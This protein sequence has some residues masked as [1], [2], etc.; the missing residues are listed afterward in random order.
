MPTNEFT[1][2]QSIH[3]FKS[4]V[5]YLRK[6]L[7][8]PID[9]ETPADELTFDYKASELGI[10]DRL[11]VKVKEIKQLRPLTGNQPWGVFWIQF[12][13]KQLP[14]VVMRRILSALVKKQRGRSG[15]QKMWDLPDLMFISATG[16]GN[17]RGISFAHFQEVDGKPQLRTFAWDVKET[18]L[19][20]IKNVNL[21][22]LRWPTDNGRDANAWQEQWSEAFSVPHRYVPTTAEMLAKKMAQIASY[23]REAVKLIYGMEHVGRGS[24]HKLHMNLKL[25]LISDLSEDD[26]ADM[27]AQ[28]VTYGLFA[29]RATRSGGFSGSDAT[30]LIEH[31]NPFLRELLEQM[32]NQQSLD[33]DELGVT[34]LTDLL[35]KVNMEAILQSFGKQKRGEDPVIHFYETFMREYDPAQKTKR[36]EFYTPDAV[37]SFI[38]R[39]VD[40]LLKTEFDCPDGLATSSANANG[41]KP[42]ILDPATGTGTFLKY[43]VEVIWETFYEKNRKLSNKDRRVKWNRFVRENVLPR[44]YAFELK[45]SPYTI[46]HMKVG[47][48]LQEKGFDFDDGER[49]QIYLTNALQPA[50]EVARV[51]TAALAH[52]AER[53]N[54]V[55]NKAPIT[56]VI[57]NPPYSGHSA[58]ASRDSKGDLNFVGKLLQDYYKVD[59]KPLGE[60]NPKW[61]QDDYVKFLRFAQWRINKSEAG[62]VAMITNHGYLDNPTFRGMRQQLIQTFDEIYILDLHGNL[63]KKETSPDGSKDENVFDIQ[64][65]VA[66]C[67]FVKHLHGTGN[68]R[69]FHANLYGTRDFK[70][71]WLLTHHSDVGSINWTPVSPIT[72]FYFFIPQSSNL[73]SEYNKGW[74]I[75]DIFKVYSLGIL[76]KRDS[77]VI[78][79]NENILLKRMKS[80]ADKSLRDVDA[81]NEFGLAMQDKDRWNLPQ[82][83][84][85]LQ[86]EGV[87]KKNIRELIYRPFDMQYVYYDAELVAR[88]NRK[89]MY[90]LEFSNLALIVG[91]QG[92]ATGSEIWD[93]A[94]ATNHLVDQNI[95]RRG[96]GTVFPL[97]LYTEN[98]TDLFMYT[99]SK[100][101]SPEKVANLGAA[102]VREFELG[103]GMKLTK[104]DSGNLKTTFGL[105]DIFFYTY[106]ILYS[107]GYRTRY[108]EF[109]ALDFPRIPTTKNLSLFVKLVALGKRL[110]M[111]HTLEADIPDDLIEKL[112]LS[113]GPNIIDKGYPQYSNEVIWIN[114]SQKFV[115]I[116]KEVWEFEIGGYQVCYKWLKDRQGERLLEDEIRRFKTIIY[117]VS[118]TYDLMNEIDEIIPSWPIE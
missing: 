61:L 60:K 81:A 85:H 38:V 87:Q 106:A 70:Y 110:Y 118:E 66:I 117:S 50:H 63:K 92:G 89:V 20:Y 90:H 26:F 79:K 101:V 96:G 46:A 51:D 7:N 75:A 45:M 114:K 23:I 88:L 49:L 18:H 97:Y 72:P 53:S 30:A 17:E 8:W 29:A 58:N 27:Y 2:V 35:G 3:D 64:Q 31:T 47:L 83:R 111:L 84:K 100:S 19:Y 98:V 112:G 42:V 59:G 104:E 1:D 54:E 6:G 116:T 39:S 24:L 67:F 34:E 56:V 94:F 32:M 57:G 76:T 22:A 9:E 105:S 71:E 28:T 10:D 65:G 108:A 91:R 41:F 69:V 12:E 16:E 13:Q 15:H 4:L 25:D 103:L 62:I 73:Q 40:H 52:E 86:T 14:V 37:V 68:A 93:V 5:K 44:L 107:N 102:F 33:L 77:L 99:S 78:D 11:A 43:V 80:F 55:K 48:A 95:F 74:S 21:D 115:N 82:A 109:L 113:D 36:G